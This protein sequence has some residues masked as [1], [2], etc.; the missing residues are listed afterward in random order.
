MWQCISSSG[1]ASGVTDTA[2]V[3][4]TKLAAQGP[5]PLKKLMVPGE[6]A[7]S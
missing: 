2:V 3:L 1:G 4:E 7:A 6:W 5:T